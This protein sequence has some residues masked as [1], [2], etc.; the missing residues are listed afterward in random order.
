MSHLLENRIIFFTLSLFLVALACLGPEGVPFKQYILNL[1]FTE[2]QVLASENDSYFRVPNSPIRIA[3]FIIAFYVMF[4]SLRL[5]IKEN[6]KLSTTLIKVIN[7]LIFLFLIVNLITNNGS[8]LI[9]ISLFA[10][11]MFY[12]LFRKNIIDD[13]YSRIEILLL[14]SMFLMFFITIFSSIYHESSLTEIDNYSRFL[15]FI[16]IYLLL[17]DIKINFTEFYLVINITSIITGLVALYYFFILG[18]IRVSVYSSS[19][20]I[21]GNISLLLMVFSY[22]TIKPYN[23]SSKSLLLPTLGVF[24][25]FVAW[26]L[27]GTRGSLLGV[28]I[29]LLILFFNRKYRKGIFIPDIKVIIASIFFFGIAISQTTNVHRFTEGFNSGYNY[30]VYGEE[31]NWKNPDS[32]MPRLIIWKGSYNILKDNLIFGV[33][34]DKFNI[35]LSEQIEDKKI[36][37]IRKDFKNP[38]AGLNHAHN[39]YLDIFAKMGIFGFIL[40]IL[41]LLIN[42]NFFHQKFKSSSLLK[43]NIALFGMTTIVMYMSHMMTHAVFS[44]H[45][46]TIFMLMVLILFF[47]SIINLEK[48]GN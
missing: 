15:L 46:S 20:I 14:C 44:H 32:I 25:A 5:P 30:I 10:I 33:G 27:T 13:D 39:Q 29:L 38:T 19:A 18:E 6:V 40:L 42:I 26:S 22:L 48:R 8:N 28:I 12:I 1:D 16:P 31:T 7:Y 41:F 36:P 9:F 35:K 37:M 34:L 45:H 21:Y 47:S 24:F 11:S 17:R 43:Q 23:D 3:I 2:L 4:Q